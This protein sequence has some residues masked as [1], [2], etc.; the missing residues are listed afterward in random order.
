MQESWDQDAEARLSAQC[1]EER[2][3][4]FRHS[5]LGAAISKDSGFTDNQE[6]LDSSPQTPSFSSGSAVTPVD[7]KAPLETGGHG[8]THRHMEID[9]LN[10]S[11]RNQ[12]YSMNIPDNNASRAHHR[13]Y[14]VNGY[15]TETTV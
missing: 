9:A 11:P 10:C 7:S 5:K 4:T 13:M 12:R 3:R 14:N 2:V 8:Q 1:I 6:S 15:S